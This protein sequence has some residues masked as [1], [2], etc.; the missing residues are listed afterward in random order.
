MQIDGFDWDAGNLEKCSSHGVSLVEIE[1]LFTRPH[2]ITP[3]VKHS[4]DEERFLAIGHTDA[5]RPLFLVFTTRL[6][7][8]RLLVR[9]I[10]ARYMHV[11]EFRRYEW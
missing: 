3:D 4:G 9:P 5:G 8:G 10:S 6:N 11:K 7:A 2:R 1:S